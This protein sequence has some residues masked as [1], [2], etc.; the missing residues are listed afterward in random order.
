MFSGLV[1]AL[2]LTPLLWQSGVKS[3]GS[4]EPPLAASLPPQATRAEP[5]NAAIVSVNFMFGISLVC[6]GESPRVARQGQAS[7]A[8]GTAGVTRPSPHS[9]AACP[10]NF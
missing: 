7:R 4:L 2:Q 1:S 8:R 10:F 5:I 3:F 9:L 6:L